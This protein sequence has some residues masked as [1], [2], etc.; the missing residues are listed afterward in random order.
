MKNGKRHGT[1]ENYRPADERFPG[2]WFKQDYANG[3]EIRNAYDKRYEL[4]DGF[5]KITHADGTIEEANYLSGRQN[6]EYMKKWNDGTIE[7][8]QI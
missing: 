8:G 1:W 4:E 2:Y 6:G 3:K 5:H 7:M